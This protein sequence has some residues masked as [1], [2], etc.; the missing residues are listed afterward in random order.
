VRIF[1]NRARVRR[2][3]AALAEGDEVHILQALSGG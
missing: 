2:L 1:V 3:D